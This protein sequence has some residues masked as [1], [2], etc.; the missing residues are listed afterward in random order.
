M[1]VLGLTLMALKHRHVI[2]RLNN[3]WKC[4]GTVVCNISCY[5]YG[6]CF[7]FKLPVMTR[8]GSL[9]S[10]MRE[11]TCTTNWDY[12][13]AVVIMATTLGVNCMTFV[14]IFLIIYVT[15]CKVLPSLTFER[16]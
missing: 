1:L 15:F 12:S 14:N 11:G 7:P 3:I 5:E 8:I 4:E 2:Q 10:P 13:G 6:Q 16:C 9:L